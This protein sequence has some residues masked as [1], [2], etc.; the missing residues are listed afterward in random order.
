MEMNKQKSNISL[1]IR[2]DVHNI[3]KDIYI[4]STIIPLEEAGIIWGSGKLNIDWSL[5]QLT[6]MTQKKENK[7]TKKRVWYN[8]G[9]YL[10]L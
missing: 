5:N 2:I 8:Q 7:H 1:A 10:V 4:K 3:F 6:P 9:C